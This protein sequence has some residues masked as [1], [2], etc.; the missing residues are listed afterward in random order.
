[1]CL[2][3]VCML[4]GL[5]RPSHNRHTT[6]ET[7]HLAGRPRPGRAQSLEWYDRFIFFFLQSKLY[8]KVHFTGLQPLS[9][10]NTSDLT[11]ENLKVEDRNFHIPPLF[12][13][14]RLRGYHSGQVKTKHRSRSSWPASR[15]LSR[16]LGHY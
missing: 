9:S 12:R 3:V 6:P 10:I 7:G 13:W 4:D 2:V 11:M 5:F 16:F 8:Y 15:I 1:M 14:K